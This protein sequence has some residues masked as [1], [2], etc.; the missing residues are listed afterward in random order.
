MESNSKEIL[1]LLQKRQRERIE[2]SI[3]QWCQDTG[4]AYIYDDSPERQQLEIDYNEHLH[5]E[6]IRQQKELEEIKAKER[7]AWINS[8]IESFQKN[9]PPRYKNASIK[10]LKMNDQTMRILNGASAVIVGTNGFGKTNLL[11]AL[12]KEW[13]AKGETVEIISAQELL[14]NIKKQDNGLYDYIKSKYKTA[15]NHLMIDEIDKIFES[16]ADH[17]YLNYL[18]NMRYEWL[19]Q[20]VFIG[21]GSLQELRSGLG[22]SIID[23]LTKEGGI[24]IDCSKATRDWRM[25]RGNEEN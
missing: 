21:N 3:K 15:V 22:N 18:V 2:Q 10:Q 25:D 19:L 12:A 23:R 11:Y 24:S 16:K 13:V 17:I 14:Y 8:R 20:T 9:I 1:N 6:Q 7:E 4:R 5:Q